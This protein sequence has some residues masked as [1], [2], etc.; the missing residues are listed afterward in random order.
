MSEADTSRMATFLKDHPRM[1]GALFALAVL[2]TQ[3][4]TV[5]A[6]GSCYCTGP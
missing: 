1:L 4:G 5:L 2:M 6:D 3:A